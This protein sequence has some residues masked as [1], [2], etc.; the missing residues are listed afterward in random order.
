M[1]LVIV[2]V[3]A[4][5]TVTVVV[6]GVAE[7]VPTVPLTVYTV[8]LV[9]LAVTVSILVLLKPI[10]GVQLYAVTPLAV[11]LIKLPVQIVPE[12]TAIVGFVTTVIVAV[13]DAVQVP[14]EPVTV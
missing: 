2:G 6:T 11:N 9:G 5:L 13:A 7:Q 12:F 10:G 4:E 8:V 14:I 1:L 3:I